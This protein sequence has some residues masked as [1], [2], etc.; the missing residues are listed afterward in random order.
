MAKE[1]SPDEQKQKA[2]NS[3]DAKMTSDDIPE[4][5]LQLEQALRQLKLLHIKVRKAC[6][7]P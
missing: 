7:C 1:M 5:E 2:L 3:H 6:G 4:A